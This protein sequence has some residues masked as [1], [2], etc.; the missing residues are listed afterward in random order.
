MF[1]Y[2]LSDEAVSGAG[3]KAKTDKGKDIPPRI[4][5]LK[6]ANKK[7]AKI[8]SSNYCQ[9]QVTSVN[10]RVDLELCTCV[11]VIIGCLCDEIN[12]WYG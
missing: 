7:Q 12:H 11:H 8:V 4:P 10:I 6:D 5:G 9:H 3:K 2:C 1:L